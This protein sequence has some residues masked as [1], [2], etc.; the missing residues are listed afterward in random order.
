VDPPPPSETTH[1][2][3]TPATSQ[4][5]DSSPS[6]G[7][8]ALLRGTAAGP[9]D[10]AVAGAPAGPGWAALKWFGRCLVWGGVTCC[11]RRSCVGP[12]G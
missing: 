12:S 11:V 5:V 3:T 8:C 10:G 9:T 1:R 7:A 2:P 6:S 4:Q